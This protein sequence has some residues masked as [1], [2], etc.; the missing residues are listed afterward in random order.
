M[1]I[2][3]VSDLHLGKGGFLKSGQVNIMEDF[4]D[5]DMFRE[6]LEFYSRGKYEKE[7]VHLVLNGDILNLLA[8][9]VDG[10][11]THIIDDQ[12]SCR[13]VHMIAKGHKVFFNAIKEFLKKENKKVSYIIGNHDIGMLFPKAQQ[14][15]CKIVEA[16]VPFVESLNFKGIHIEH[17]HRFDPLNNVPRFKQIVKGPN[18]KMVL[19]LP[20]GSL[21]CILVLPQLKKERPNI[22][23]V[24]P[25]SKYAKWMF[26]YDFRF[27]IKAI[28]L[29]FNSVFKLTG[30]K[31][32]QH[33]KGFYA[34]VKLLRQFAIY[35]KYA[36]LTRQLMKRKKNLTT[37]VI[38]HTHIREW[39]RFP[40]GKLYLNSGTWNII[41]SFDVGQHSDEKRL[42]YLYLTVNEANHEL[43]EA[44]INSWQGEWKPFTSDGCLTSL[45]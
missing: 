40:D 35:P 33:S 31:D 24:R 7:K 36:K 29:I 9:D 30:R 26:Y 23:K 17:G 22:D 34:T 25:M 45:L 10:V 19:N 14:A 37:M 3:V 4:H 27:F 21:F 11:F 5:D 41:P 18:G 39:R 1:L 28:H 2:L 8:V 16:E 32:F 42:T 38:G 15:F 44:S 13:A 43:L 6:M 20:W 12:V